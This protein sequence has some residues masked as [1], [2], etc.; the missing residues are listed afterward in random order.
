MVKTKGS[1]FLT[2]GI[3]K[4]KSKYAYYNTVLNITR[5]VHVIMMVRMQSSVILSHFSGKCVFQVIDKMFKGIS[6]FLQNRQVWGL[7]FR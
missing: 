6:D 3:V 4:Q 2:M 7:Y 5:R 1:S